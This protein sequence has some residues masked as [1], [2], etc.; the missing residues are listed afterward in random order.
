MPRKESHEFFSRHSKRPRSHM[1][2][3]TMV[4]ATNDYE[5]PSPLWETALQFLLLYSVCKQCLNVTAPPHCN[6]AVK[7]H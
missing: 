2:I 4:S 1:P 7:F 3:V 6:S 5:V